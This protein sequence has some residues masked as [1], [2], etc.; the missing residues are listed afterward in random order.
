[1]NKI[2]FGVLCPS[3][4]AFR[5]FM[6]ALKKIDNAEFI[7]IA[8]A[9]EE[10]WFGSINSSH[11][12]TVLESDT[13]KAKTFIDTYGGKLFNSFKELIFSN[14]VDAIY[15]PLLPAL[16]YKWAKMALEHHKHVLV[17]KPSTT[18]Y[19]DTS[20]LISIAKENNLAL[21]E[22]YMFNFHSQLDSIEKIINDGILGEIRLYRIAFGFPF[23]GANDFRYKKKMGGGALL[24]CGG[25]TIKLANRLL[26]KTS[27]LIAHHLNYKD[28][29]EVDIYGSGTLMN[30]DGQVAQISFGMDNAY[31]CELEIWGSKAT[32]ITG[33]VLTAPDGFEPTVFIKDN[34]G[35]REIKL[36]SDDSFKKS[37]NYFINCISNNKIRED[38]FDKILLQSHIVDEFK[39]D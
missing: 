23:R 20:N 29:F 6:P 37:I 27:K 39:E 28:G 10:E 8:H 9:D 16:H 7:G 36:Q 33:R 4:I 13:N 18:S 17:E 11:D 38:N 1:M 3:E 2:R 24:D 31:K 34:S 21:H 30:N 26:G 15:I 35:T 25:Y 5:R 19:A 32:L 12:L 22:N 14:E